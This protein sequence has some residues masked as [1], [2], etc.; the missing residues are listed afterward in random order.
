MTRD[1][2]ASTVAKGFGVNGTFEFNGVVFLKSGDRLSINVK[3]RAA[4]IMNK[5]EAYFHVKQ[6]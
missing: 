2:K 4:V 3:D 1:G 5:G 6:I